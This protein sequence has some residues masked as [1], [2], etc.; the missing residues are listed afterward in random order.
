MSFLDAFHDRKKDKVYVS[1]IVDGSIHTVEYPAEYVFYYS[2][3]SGSHKSIFGDSCKKYSTNNSMKFRKEL[4]KIISPI[5]NQPPV[6]IFESDIKPEFR[7]LADHYMGLDAPELNIGFFDIETDFDKDRGHAPITDPFN[8]ITAISLYTSNNQ[9]MIT[10]VLLPKTYT[11]EDGERIVSNFTDTYLFDSEAELL[12]KFLE[13]FE[14]VHVC[15]GWNSTFFDIPYL[16]NRITRVLGKDRTRDMCLWGQLPKEGKTKK[17]KREHQTYDLI[18]RVHLDYLEL[19][20]KH[21]PQQLHS[22]GLNFV[23]EHEDCGSKTQYEGTLDDLYNK[24]FD[25]FIEYNRQ[26]TFLLVKIDAKKKFIELANQVAHANCVMLKTT[27]GTVSLVE[28]AITNETHKLLGLVV[29]SRKVSIEEYDEDDEEERHLP[30][31]GAYVADP[32]TGLQEEIG[33]VDI[34]S[35]YPSVIRSLNMSIETIFGHIRPIETDAFIAAK[36]KKLGKNKRAEAWEGIFRTYEVEH[37][38]TPNDKTILTIDFENGTSKNMLACDLYDYIFNPNNHLCITANGT[39]FKTNTDG[40][41]PMLLGKWFTERMEMQ[42][43]Q[44]EFEELAEKATSEEDKLS[45]QI[46]AKFWNQRQQTRKILLNSLYGALLNE[47]MKFSDKRIGKSV[48]LTGRCVAKHM[49]SKINEIVV[50]KYDYKGDAIIYADTDSFANDSKIHT[51]RGTLSVEALFNLLPV[52]W[53]DGEKEY[54]SCEDTKVLSYDPL[55]DKAIFKN[56][57]YVYRHR[58]KKERWKI[59]DNLGN[60]IICTGDHSVMIERDGQLQE[61]K[62]RDIKSDDIII[63]VIEKANLISDLSLV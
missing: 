27:M 28:Q 55:Q 11:M 1:E 39:I 37:M 59:T 33:C 3:P 21:N 35:L 51:T 29:P 32:K 42:A 24:D 54:A 45:F 22:Y 44:R 60:E 46:Q 4:G 57:N 36:V 49:N 6:K 52:R 40:I 61:I 8:A 16:V 12:R 2:H 48:T 31:V 53:M 50:G 23:G 30:V 10:L 25:R 17:F 9:K 41:I 14:P 43:K 56:I 47:V 7:C 5:S 13:I 15:S 20:Q 62:P 18:G 19:Y 38:F 58:V 63:S 34:T 26:D